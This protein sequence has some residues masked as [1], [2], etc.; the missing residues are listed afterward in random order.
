[1][2]LHVTGQRCTPRFARISWAT[3]HR[4]AVDAGSIRRGGWL[5]EEPRERS[6][7]GDSSELASAPLSERG[8]SQDDVSAGW[9]Q[10]SSPL[11]RG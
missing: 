6:D 11:M 2:G 1:M 9:A 5:A 3:S 10:L 7:R 4:R 8:Y